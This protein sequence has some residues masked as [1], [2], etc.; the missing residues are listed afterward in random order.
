MLQINEPKLEPMGYRHHKLA[1]NHSHFLDQVL[2]PV[3]ITCS[4]TAS[5]D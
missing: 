5:V 2:Q 4:A 3:L 1:K